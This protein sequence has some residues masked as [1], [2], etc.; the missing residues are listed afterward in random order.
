MLTEERESSLVFIDALCINQADEDEKADQIRF[1][2]HIY[3]GAREVVAWMGAGSTYGAIIDPKLPELEAMC[4]SELDS[5][6]LH[7][8]CEDYSKTEVK[9]AFSI[10]FLNYAY[11][12]RLWIMQ[13]TI[14]AGLLVV[15]F[16]R[17]RLPAGIL[18]DIIDSMGFQSRSDVLD[19]SPIMK[20]SLSF[21]EQMSSLEG[22]K[23]RSI[24]LRKR[25]LTE[26]E[27]RVFSSQ[28]NLC[29][30]T[31]SSLLIYRNRLDH[32]VHGGTAMTIAHAIELSAAQECSRPHDKI[33][34]I[35]ALTESVLTPSYYISLTELYI[36]LLIE[37][38]LEFKAKFGNETYS[39]NRGRGH[40]ASDE[41][42]LYNFIEAFLFK[43]ELSPLHLTTG[44][45]VIYAL[46][47][48]DIQLSP[49]V[50]L[51]EASRSAKSMEDKARFKAMPLLLHWC[52]MRDRHMSVPGDKEE[53]TIVCDMFS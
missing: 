28:A 4:S 33:F 10:A 12:S 38:L 27:E 25:R 37:A 52:F 24:F 14:L 26:L 48:C 13:E 39:G 41:R 3:R 1:M 32:E 21:Q 20:A 2:R 34:G 16:R 15:R 50:W 40:L 36:Q 17:L 8:L 6:D 11:W 22:G 30:L 18:E 42:N 9:R 44:I 35:L 23:Q 53:I 49:T 31:I 7:T 46:G 51:S 47:I 29:S 5:A 43:M 19:G 45:I